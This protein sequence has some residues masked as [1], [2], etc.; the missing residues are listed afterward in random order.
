MVCMHRQLLG[1]LR[2]KLFVSKS[3]PTY[4]RENAKAIRITSGIVRHTELSVCLGEC[5]CY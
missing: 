5:V 2:L 4:H 3:T 1:E